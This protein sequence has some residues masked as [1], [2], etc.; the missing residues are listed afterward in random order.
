MRLFPLFFLL[1]FALAAYGQQE[2]K[3]VAILNTTGDGDLTYLSVKLRE[4][5]VKILPKDKYSIMTAESI[6]DKLGSKENANKV[7]KEAQCLAV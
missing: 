3:R 4:I 6:I 5:A 7:C 2:Q 1:L